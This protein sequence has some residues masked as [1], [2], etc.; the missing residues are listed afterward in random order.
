M[1]EAQLRGEGPMMAQEPPRQLKVLDYMGLAWECLLREI[2]LY[3]MS[4]WEA[5]PHA[6]KVEVNQ[7]TGKAVP[8]GSKGAYTDATAQEALKRHGQVVQNKQFMESER[9]IYQRGGMIA[10]VEAQVMEG[11]DPDRGSTHIGATGAPTFPSG[12]RIEITEMMAE[13]ANA[14]MEVTMEEFMSAAGKVWC[15]PGIGRDE[16]FYRL[17]FKMLDY[18]NSGTVNKGQFAHLGLVSLVQ[19]EKLMDDGLSIVSLS[20]NRLNFETLSK[21]LDLGP[22]AQFLLC[23]CFRIKN[24]IK[25]NE[26]FG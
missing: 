25:I 8:R 24:A 22:R 2:G 13:C 15:V 3:T 16:V 23:L 20:N 6:D 1:E 10:G 17:L 11:E 18:N 9:L 14:Q 26:Y 5:D 19:L 4:D 7:R 12:R 21:P